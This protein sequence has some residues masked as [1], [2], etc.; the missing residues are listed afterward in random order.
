LT[1]PLTAG[2]AKLATYELHSKMSVVPRQSAAP[3]RFVFAV[4][5]RKTDQVL[6]VL[7][8]TSEAE[9]AQ[10]IRRLMTAITARERA[11]NIEKAEDEA[12][13][14]EAGQPG[15]GNGAV[16]IAVPPLR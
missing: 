5:D 14:K 1:C 7:G 11:A 6:V 9:R 2:G 13:A 12:K 8:A 3:G 15:A 16:A 10:W 4:E